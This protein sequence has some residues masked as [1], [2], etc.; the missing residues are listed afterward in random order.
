MKFQ[1]F[2]TSTNVQNVLCFQ[3][4]LKKHFDFFL[5]CVGRCRRFSYFAIATFIMRTRRFLFTPA[6]TDLLCIAC[7]NERKRLTTMTFN[8]QIDYANLLLIE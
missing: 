4:R 5:L 8:R 7:V 1:T 6:S 2:T 3:L